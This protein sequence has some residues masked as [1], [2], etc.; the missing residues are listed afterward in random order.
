MV[1]AG[2]TNGGSLRFFMNL[3]WVKSGVLFPPDTGGRKR[4]LG[5][6]REI[7]C[8]GHCI[9]YLGLQ[10]R[11]KL[12]CQAELADGYAKR[13][14]W[15]PSREPQRGSPRFF[16]DL[17]CNLLFSRQPYVLDRYRSGAWRERI[18]AAA[19]QAD[20]IVCDFLTPAPQFVGL[21]LGKPIVLFQHN[22]ESQIWKRLADSA[23][24]PLKRAYLRSQQRRMWQAEKS[25][26]ARFDGV[27][28]V[29]PED[30]AFCREQYGLRN[31]LG[32]VPTGVD[33]SAFQVPSQPPHEPTVGFLGSMDWMPNIEGVQWMVREV[34]PLLRQQLPGVRLKIIGRHPPAVIQALDQ[35]DPAIEVTGT[36]PD[37]QPHV[38]Q[39]SVI[40]VP[41]LAGGGTRIKIYE[42]M[43]MGVPVV[44]TTIGAEGLPLK[45]GQDLLI[46]DTASDF[47]TALQ[48]LLSAPAQAT[49]LA[50]QARQRVEDEFSWAAAATRF[51]DFCQRLKEKVSHGGTEG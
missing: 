46:A 39:C 27:I 11:S 13:K 35:A 40:A 36:V 44:S 1:H 38:H 51:M 24:H 10:P 18:S 41:L 34:L 14:D 25:L 21:R 28:T 43:A 7:Q 17:A 42:A 32:E 23:H 16:V 8:A 9:H 33:V 3:L 4:T 6:L 47:A 30:S 19:Q 49:A 29:S 37:V 22:I 31:V 20:L 2:A 26:S 45:S 48:R 50:R 5:M 12:V 15:V